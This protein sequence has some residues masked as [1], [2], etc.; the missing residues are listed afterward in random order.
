MRDCGER[1]WEGDV[2]SRWDGLLD[3]IGEMYSTLPMASG[4]RG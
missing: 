3:W 2:A 1:K 4:Q